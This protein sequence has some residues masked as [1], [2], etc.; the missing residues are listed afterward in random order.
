MKA[1]VRVLPLTVVLLI[2]LAIIACAPAPQPTAVPPTAAPQPTAAQAQPTAAPAMSELDKLYAAAKAEG[3]LTTIALPHDWCNYAG[4]F[5]GFKKKYPGIT[6]NELNPDAGSGDEIE[7][8]KANKDNKGPQA[9]DVVDVGFAFGESGKKD[10]L[11]QPYKVSTWADIP[12]GA[13][14][15]EGYWYGDYYGVM[16]FM[17]N[18]DVVKTIPT[19]WAD[20]LKPE[21]K[22]QIGMSGDP[23]TS[24]QAIQTVQGASLANGGTVADPAKGLEYFAAMNK[25]GNLVPLIANN[26]TVAKG[27]TPIRMTWD[28]NA[29][30]GRDGM[31]GNPKIE[32]VV[33]KSGKIAGVYVQ[34]I[35]AYAPHPNAAKLW[36]EYLYSDEGQLIWLSPPGYCHPIRQDAMDKAGKIPADLKAKLPST[37]GAVFPANADLVAG[38]EVI[39][40]G[41]D[42]AVGADIKAAGAPPAQPTAAP[43]SSAVDLDALYAAAKAEGMLTT[44]ALPHDWCNYAGIFEGFKKKYPGITVNELNPDAG[45]GD[46]IEAIKANKDNKGPQ[47]PDV[48]DVGFAFG[49]S[50]KKDGLFQPYKV[51][52]WADIPDGAKDAEGYWYGDYYGVMAFMVNSDVVKTIPTDWADLLKPEYKGQIGMSGDPRTSNQ[53]IQTVQGASLANGGTVADPAKGLEYFAAMNKAGNLVPLIANNGTV[54]KGETPIR[55]TWDYNALA[56]RDGMQGNPK[57]EVVVPKSGKIAGVYVQ[58]ISAYAPHPNAAKLWM[59]Y[60]YSD[61]GQ[62]IWLSPPGY[63]HPIRQDA[64]DKAGKIPADLK[65]KLPSTEGA[66]FPANAD[67]VAGKEVIVK[68]W[69]AA[70]GADIKAGQ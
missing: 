41:W 30:A 24:N 18:S 8:I 66:V 34:A 61:E 20:L 3:M 27:E 60:L 23:R 39:V 52:T 51:S 68:G 57:I 13:K 2:A 46:E 14:D 16:A 48:V 50:G 22:G 67:L 38:K 29:L 15:A 40:K 54:A 62:L 26:G 59:E 32:V 10:G 6:V 5:E 37:E 36:M 58:A 31:Q 42:A 47:A 55:M 4:I 28:Y 1:I 64:M 11:F 33:P 7:A 12:D 35:S 17:V 25:A 9:P 63:C 21:Y 49:E 65:A 43:S 45:S 44:I 56:G 70:V 69:D 19:D 53:A